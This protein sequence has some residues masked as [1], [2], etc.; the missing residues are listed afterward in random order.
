M[1]TQTAPALHGSKFSFSACCQQSS[2]HEATATTM[3]VTTTDRCAAPFFRPRVAWWRS[4][5]REMEM[6]QRLACSPT[7][8]RY[9]VT[10]AGATYCPQAAADGQLATGKK[11]A[12]WQCIM[13]FPSEGVSYV[14]P[15]SV[16]GT[17]SCRSW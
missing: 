10:S 14:H 6:E 17:S 7:M 11:M 8:V 9:G 15:T 2:A 13:Q 12:T 5:Q 4:L 1:H 3:H 16:N